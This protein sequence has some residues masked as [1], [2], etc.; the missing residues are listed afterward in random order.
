MPA[1][2]IAIWPMSTAISVPSASDRMRSA[3]ARPYSAFDA[4]VA[5]YAAGIFSAC[6][7]SVRS[8]ARWRITARFP[9]RWLVAVTA[10]YPSPTNRNVNRRPHRDVDVLDRTPA[11]RFLPRQERVVDLHLH[12]IGLQFFIGTE[13]LASSAIIE[14]LLRS[15][16]SASRL[17]VGTSASTAG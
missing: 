10:R 12:G 4:P 6:H 3:A 1:D 15:G 5:M 2:A 16:F 17:L 11:T 13:I 9:S 7:A 8:W 14:S